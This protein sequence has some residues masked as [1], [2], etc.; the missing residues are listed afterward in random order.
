MKFKFKQ[1]ERIEFKAEGHSYTSTSG[2]DY[3]PVTSLI[4]RYYKPFDSTYWSTYKAVKDVMN[5]AGIFY[6]YKAIAGGW[7]KVPQYYH[8]NKDSLDKV[9]H[10]QIKE[11]IQ[12]YLDSWN[13]E[14]EYA[15]ALGNKAHS[16]LEGLVVSAK[17]IDLGDKKIADVSSADLLDLQGFGMGGNQIYPELLLWNERYRVAGQADIV[18]RR[19]MEVVIKDYKT[20]KK[21]EFESFMDAHMFEPLEELP[22][23][24]YSKFTIQLSTYAWMLEES[25]YRVTG[26]VVQHIDRITGKH[27]KDYP[28][29]YRKDL[30]TKMLEHYDNTR[31]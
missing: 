27:I 12:H 29:A 3:I 1:P 13:E 21:I 6:R 4:A 31:S 30:V 11:R 28:M 18:E 9:L 2:N 25:G 24:N 5:N 7:D 15:A 16:D 20:C 22:D 23:T 19:G 10:L 26:L 14:R 17:K 8:A